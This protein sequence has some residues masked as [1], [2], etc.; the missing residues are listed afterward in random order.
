MLLSRAA[1]LSVALEIREVIKI[2][3]LQQTDEI[4]YPQWKAT[5]NKQNW[6]FLAAKLS[7]KLS[8]FGWKRFKNSKYR[9]KKTDISKKKKKKS[10]LSEMKQTWI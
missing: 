5:T 2:P 3:K 4:W 10:Y 7:C 1:A 8:L 9:Y 6:S